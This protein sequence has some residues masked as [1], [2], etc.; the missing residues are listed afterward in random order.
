MEVISLRENPEYR[1]AAIRYFQE[2]WATENSMMVYENC[3]S[4]SLMTE[5]ALPLW[6]LLEDDD[7]IIGCAGLITNDFISRMDLCPWICA[8]FIEPDMRG[9]RLGGLLLARAR[10]D[11]AA[12]GFE[13]VYLATDIMGY[14][15]QFGFR[16][17]GKG[18]HPW[19]DSS[20]IFEAQTREK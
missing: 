17:I 14:Y 13:R 1:T 3:I 12:A 15:E 6:Y 2:H 7:R 18:Y 11:A 10:A 5:S 4:Y 20:L 8:L 9:R 19:G 16:H